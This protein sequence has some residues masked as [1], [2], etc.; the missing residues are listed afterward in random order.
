MDTEELLDELYP[1]LKT[2]LEIVQLNGFTLNNEELKIIDT[3]YSDKQ[4]L[5][6]YEAKF[7]QGVEEKKYNTI[8]DMF[9]KR[10]SKQNS[11]DTFAYYVDPRIEKGKKVNKYA[12]QQLVYLIGT[13]PADI[14]IITKTPLGSGAVDDLSKYNFRHFLF[15][16]LNYNIM[17]S[18]FSP[19]YEVLSDTERIEFL[20]I[21]R[22]DN[23]EKLTKMKAD[24]KISRFLNLRLGQIV[25]ITA[26][27][28][29]YDSMVTKRMSYRIVT[30]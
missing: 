22:M 2:Q 7:A 27:I 12:I 10:F 13:T 16:E 17:K 19:V 9:N 5:I 21:N 23:P 26:R 29:Y 24:D 8:Y 14:I 6:D 4:F 11:A 25:R 20:R 3:S 18:I 28:I 1:I 30:D 15:S